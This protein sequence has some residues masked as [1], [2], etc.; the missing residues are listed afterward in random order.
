MTDGDIP[1]ETRERT[2]A[3]LIRQHRQDLG[4]TQ[5][6]LAGEMR[7]LDVPWTQ[8]IVSRVERGERELSLPEAMRVTDVL[9][10]DAGTVWVRRIRRRHEP[11]TDD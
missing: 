3:W 10:I 8:R 4:W 1:Y 9:G 7:R 2:V 5:E 11:P 6:D